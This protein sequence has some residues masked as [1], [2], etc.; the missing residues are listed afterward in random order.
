MAVTLGIAITSGLIVGFV[1]SR[2]PSPVE[3]FDDK[4]H[5]AHVDYTEDFSQY[6]EKAGKAVH[7]EIQLADNSERINENE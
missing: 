2:L 3:L 7:K 6:N 1:A 5:F 4:P